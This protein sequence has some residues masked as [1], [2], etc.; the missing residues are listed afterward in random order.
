MF[1]F[2]NISCIPV[3]TDRLITSVKKIAGG[4]ECI[5][6]VAE[7]VYINGLIAQWPILQQETDRMLMI[8]AFHLEEIRPLCVLVHCHCYWEA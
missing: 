8:V 6:K 4:V 2:L 1:T 7:T 5:F 3:V